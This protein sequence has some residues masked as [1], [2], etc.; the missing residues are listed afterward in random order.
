M[1]NLLRNEK[2]LDFGR[3]KIDLLEIPV[4]HL[5]RIEGTSLVETELCTTTDIKSTFRNS[6][7]RDIM[8]NK[9]FHLMFFHIDLIKN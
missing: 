5:Q 6:F 9:F 8:L 1:S 3:K 7:S 2:L 4:E